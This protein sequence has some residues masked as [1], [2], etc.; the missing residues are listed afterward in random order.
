[1]DPVRKKKQQQMVAS[2]LSDEIHEMTDRIDSCN[3]PSLLATKTNYS[4]KWSNTTFYVRISFLSSEVQN[5]FQDET[6]ITYNK[7]EIGFQTHYWTF[8]TS[9][10]K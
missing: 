8:Y 10:Y 1:M 5:C 7:D 6:K 4:W 9:L 3:R 2:L